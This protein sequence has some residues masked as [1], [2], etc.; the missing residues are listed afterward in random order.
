MTTFIRPETAA[1]LR[2]RSCLMDA[3]ARL[4]EC[5]APLAHAAG[6]LT[7]TLRNGGR[8]LAAGNGGS[9]AQAGHFAAE[10]VGRFLCE[11]A[12]FAALAL[13]TDMST[14]TAV[15]N[16]YGYHEVFARQVAGL[17]RPGDAFVGFSTSGNS[18]NLIRA[19]HEA[20]AGEL[21]VIALT[22]EG[23]NRLSEL[24]TVSIH[25]PSTETPTIQELH[26]VMVHYL[27]GVVEQASIH[28]AR[29]G[30]NVQ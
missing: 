9:A 8:V 24:A 30:V 3:L 12:P 1:L 11:R 19:A 29:V 26:L 14:L 25:A 21:S 20:L 15:A 22:G 27:A 13:T 17:G 7:A 2:G 23:P 10:L 5:S 6:I 4:D 18:E 16:D 28:S